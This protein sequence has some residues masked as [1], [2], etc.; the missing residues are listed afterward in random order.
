MT[1]AGAVTATAT[2]DTGKTKRNA[3]TKKTEKVLYKPTCQSVVIPTSPADAEAFTG[4]VHLFFA[5]SP[6]NNFPGWSGV[7]EL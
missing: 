7:V 6:A 1:T 4:E 2:F 3:K 5:P